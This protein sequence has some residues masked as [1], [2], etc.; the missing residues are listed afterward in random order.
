MNKGL[1]LIAAALLVVSVAYSLDRSI[2]VGS[3]RVL[4]DP[5]PCSHMKIENL[6]W[7]EVLPGKEP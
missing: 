7:R 5:A 6:K 2:F 1:L 3:E 4:Y